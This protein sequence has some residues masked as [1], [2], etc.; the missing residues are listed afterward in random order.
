MFVNQSE[1]NQKMKSDEI[2]TISLDQTYLEI[3]K[4]LV[5]TLETENNKL[6]KIIQQILKSDI[7]K[8]T[9]N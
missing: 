7:N 8:Y 9:N 1:D 5:E 6:H 4:K 3:C 2:N